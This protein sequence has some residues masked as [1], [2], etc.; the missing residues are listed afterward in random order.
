MIHGISKAEQEKLAIDVDEVYISVKDRV[1]MAIAIALGIDPRDCYKREL[2]HTRVDQYNTVIYVNESEDLSEE[3]VRQVHR[4]LSVDKELAELFALQ[5][6][7]L[8]GKVKK[9]V[10]GFQFTVSWSLARYFQG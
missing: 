8:I 3:T 5:A 2:Q 10:D 7:W 1:A 6:G 4:L 9:D